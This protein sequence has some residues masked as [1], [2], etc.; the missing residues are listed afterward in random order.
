MEESA[1]LSS[2]MVDIP[3]SKIQSICKSDLD[4][5]ESTRHEIFREAPEK[6]EET[7]VTGFLPADF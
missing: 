5:N 7:K 4:S 3:R 2:S 1:N 6:S